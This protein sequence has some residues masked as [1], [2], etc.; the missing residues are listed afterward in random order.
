MQK[1][2][3]QHQH[4]GMDGMSKDETGEY[5]HLVILKRVASD[6]T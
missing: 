3:C 5:G 6:V 2:S 1:K 4:Y